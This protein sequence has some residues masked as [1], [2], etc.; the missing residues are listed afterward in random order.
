MLEDYLRPEPVVKAF[1]AKIRQIAH[2]A[3]DYLIALL[4]CCISKRSISRFSSKV[5]R[6]AKMDREVHKGLETIQDHLDVESI[7]KLNQRVRALERLILDEDE[8]K[9]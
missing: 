3:L 6:F 9:F 1:R 8:A 5:D 4:C 7:I 2:D